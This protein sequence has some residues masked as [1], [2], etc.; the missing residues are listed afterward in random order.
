ME[1]NLSLLMSLFNPY[2]PMKYLFILIGIALLTSC[3]SKVAIEK[4]KVREVLTQFGKENPETNVL[5]HT[6][7]GDMEVKLYEE[8]PLHR[9][10]FIRLVKAGYYDE[11]RFYRIVK[12]V[13]VQGGSRADPQGYTVPAEFRPN[14]IHKKGALAMARYTEDNPGKESSATEFFIITKGRFYNEEELVKY[15]ENLKQIYLKQGGEMLFDQAYTVFGEVT[16]GIEVVEKIA[17]G[18]VVDK[19]TPVKVTTFSIKVLN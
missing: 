4:D 10:N 7:L 9:A 12:G 15:P 19:E 16:K 13:C 5:I 6:N 8:T 11:R 2:Q 1:K 14:L 3:Q 18:Q 17:K